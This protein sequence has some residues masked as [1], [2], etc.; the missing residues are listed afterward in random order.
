MKTF[1]VDG[2]FTRPI[3][4]NEPENAEIFKE[5]MEFLDRGVS[6]GWILLTGG[7]FEAEG[8]G[9]LI[10]KAEDKDAVSAIMDT[11]PF[12]QKNINNYVIKEF[13]FAKGQDAVGEWFADAMPI[14]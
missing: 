2:S 3:D 9:I 14:R 13:G 4:F 7:K 8:G 6:E 5:H 10:I 1:L 11:D 12:K